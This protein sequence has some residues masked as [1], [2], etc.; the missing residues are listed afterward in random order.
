M[1]YEKRFLTCS[2]PPSSP[3]LA[4]IWA[5]LRKNWTVVF[6][7]LGR[8]IKQP[9]HLEADALEDDSHSNTEPV[10]SQSL[11]QHKVVNV[12]RATV[13]SKA[14]PNNA[15]LVLPS[16]A[17]NMSNNNMSVY[18]NFRAQL[19]KNGTV[20]WRK[21]TAE[22]NTV[23]MNNYS[24][25]NG[26]FEPH[27]YVHVTSLRTETGEHVYSCQCDIHKAIEEVAYRDADGTAVI[28]VNGMKCC[29][30]RFF[31]E[32]ITPILKRIGMVRSSSSPS[33]IE[34]KVLEGIVAASASIV[35][36]PHLPDSMK[37]SVRHEDTLAF[38]H[39]TFMHQTRTHIVSCQSG[40]CKAAMKHRRTLKLLTNSH[41]LCPHLEI[42]KENPSYWE[43][44]ELA[45]PED[46]SEPT[47]E[48]PA[49]VCC[50]LVMFHCAC[51]INPSYGKYDLLYPLL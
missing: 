42:L 38:V 3:R 47:I 28:F 50:Q 26:M 20:Q 7:T 5:F 9:Q 4:V 35:K 31:E 43:D 29:H 24:S 17:E 6:Q 32:E 14:I 40:I 10:P 13:T 41:D 19:V 34:R 39:L 44:L 2:S 37:F 25:Q 36:L 21:Q 30:C 1:R 22:I 45:M 15:E 27:Q 8:L 48:N 33:F 11:R 51:D 49:K 12:S 18:D 16:L 23:V 46:A